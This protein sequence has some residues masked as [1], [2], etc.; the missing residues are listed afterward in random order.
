MFLRHV[1]YFQARTPGLISFC[2]AISLALLASNSE[3]H[4]YRH[5]LQFS[6]KYT[7]NL[8]IESK[9]QE[10]ILEETGG[11]FFYNI[12]YLKT[13]SNNIL[14]GLELEKGSATLKWDG[15][16]QGGFRYTTDSEYFIDGYRF[17][18]GRQN[19]RFATIFGIANRYRERNILTKEFEGGVQIDGL[20]EELK[21][22]ELFGKFDLYAFQNEKKHFK[23]FSELATSISGNQKVEFNGKYDPA[24]LTPG[25]IVSLAVGLEYFFDRSN[26]W[27]IALETSYKYSHMDSSK[28][29][30]LLQDGSEIGATFS[31]P[32][33]EYQELAVSLGLSKRLW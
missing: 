11:L 22:T 3:G 4:T 8:I 21:W 17:F 10:A 12:N 23:V 30:V 6:G 15:F 18:M 9:N 25:R 16:S 29:Q 5:L 33:T 27:G 31:Q 13:F 14:L 1:P 7:N 32:V 28:S 26:G 2:F 19:P 24:S 20:Y